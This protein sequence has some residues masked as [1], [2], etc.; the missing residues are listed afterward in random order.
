MAHP[1]AASTSQA[2]SFRRLL[3]DS[4]DAKSLS[5]NPLA[6]AVCAADP[7]HLIAAFQ[8]ALASSL[9]RLPARQ[10]EIVRRYDLER[11]GVD[12]ICASMAL[13]RRQFFRDHRAAI[14]CLTRL[15]VPG[16]APTVQRADKQAARPLV[17]EAS[18]LRLPII[19]VANGLRNVGAYQEAIDVLARHCNTVEAAPAKVEALLEIADIAAECGDSQRSQAAIR[20]AKAVAQQ[21]TRSPDPLCEA[22]FQLAEGQTA[23]SEPQRRHYERAV[24]VLSAL[25]DEGNADSA[26]ALLLVRSLHALSLSHDHRGDWLSA[27][28]TARRSIDLLEPFGLEETPIGL[29]ASANYAMRDARQFGSVNAVAGTLR[30]FLRVSLQHG[31]VHVTGEVAVH[32]VNLNL[33]H[34]RYAEAL[35]WRRWLSA[36]DAARLTARTRNF[37]D[38]DSAHAL[39]MLG[40]PGQAL[41]VLESGDDAGLAFVGARE[42][43]RGE[44]LLAGGD[45]ERA[46]KLGVRALE[47]ADGA[48][49]QKGRAR[50]KR[51][52]ANCYHVLGQERSARKTIAESLE[53]AQCYASPYDLFL[54]L[55]AARNIGGRS[56]L[57]NESELANL[58]RRAGEGA[59]YA[60]PSGTAL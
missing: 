24:A 44:A 16:A 43:W 42:Y 56:L 33:M 2:S 12:S 46:L 26:S 34:F 29:L 45:I 8:A 32:F 14:Q 13:S 18:P 20:E 11:E 60:P 58:L 41:L 59:E 23:A 40:R 4:N 22:R 38:V 53:L 3:R 25:H 21:V 35:A 51:L 31:W 1:T 57:G 30:R 10:H 5:A 27:R 15:M 28:V 39:T 6:R 17:F 36:I 50:S 48:D 47:G 19:S 37:L 52:L 7:D 55:A 49:S 9:H 54:S